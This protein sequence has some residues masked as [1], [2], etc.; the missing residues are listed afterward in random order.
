[1]YAASKLAKKAKPNVQELAKIDPANIDLATIEESVKIVL[2]E[3]VAL[4]ASDVVAR[5]PVY[6]RSLRNADWKKNT[7]LNGESDDSR[8]D[9]T[10]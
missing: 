1:M 2:A 9:A 3:Y 6:W 5:A 10:F 8:S 7:H 4:G